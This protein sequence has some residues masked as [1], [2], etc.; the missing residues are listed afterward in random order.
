MV[1]HIRTG[2]KRQ[3]KSLHAL[4]SVH[5]EMICMIYR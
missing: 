5:E 4:V 2:I 1:G 3:W